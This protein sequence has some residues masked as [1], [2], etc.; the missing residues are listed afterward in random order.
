MTAQFL[1]REAVGQQ[2]KT[3]QNRQPGPNQGDKLLIEDEEFLEI[4]GLRSF[5]KTT[6]PYREVL[7]PDRIDKVTLL[8]QPVASFVFAP[9]FRDLLM[10]LA[11]RICVT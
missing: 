1:V 3:F 9:C 4:N 11:S 7:R 8:G 2:I 5:L 10:H 6:E